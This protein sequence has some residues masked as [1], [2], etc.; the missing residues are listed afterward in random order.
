MDDEFV[1]Q[2]GTLD[3]KQPQEILTR[4]QK[5]NLKL[6]VEKCRFG[7]NYIGYLVYVVTPEE[8][9]ELSSYLR[10]NK[11]NRCHW[12]KNIYWHGTILLRP[13]AQKSHVLEPFTATSSGKKANKLKQLQNLNE[14]FL[15][16][17]ETIC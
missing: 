10:Y 16:V 17:Q 8:I 15:K 5:T 3:L 11:T 13:V 12:N 4:C 2:K 9:K 14:A 1:L 6:N 7:I